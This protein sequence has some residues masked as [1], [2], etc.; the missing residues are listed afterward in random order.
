MSKSDLD[1]SPA[2][3]PGVIG[4]ALISVRLRSKKPSRS[5]RESIQKGWTETVQP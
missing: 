1:Q 5:W 4:R 2:G 3:G